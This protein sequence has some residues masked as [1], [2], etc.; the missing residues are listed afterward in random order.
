M[1][2][3]VSLVSK[4]INLLKRL[5]G[6]ALVGM[7]VVTCVDVIFRGFNRPI[8]GAVEVVS[9]MATIVL[10]CAMP[11]TE[12]EN[13]HVGV[14]LFVR[15]MSARGQAW[16]DALT[17]LCSG[18]LFGLVSWQMWLYGNTVKTTGEV[19]M[20]LQFPDYIL[21]YI[22]SVAFGVLC[23]VILTECLINLRKAG[24]R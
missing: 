15:R 20:S 9:F 4:L 11:L 17:K 13:G 1:N 8:F 22:V 18:A 5:G 7:M 12:F 21:I 23:L 16:C 3:W 2:S 10:A 24:A 19:S 14:D 6:G